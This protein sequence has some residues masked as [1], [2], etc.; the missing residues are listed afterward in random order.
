MW[1]ANRTS[2]AYG[3]ALQVYGKLLLGHQGGVCKSILRRF[4]FA[5]RRFRE[6]RNLW[7]ADCRIGASHTQVTK[8]RGFGGRCL[9]KDIRALIAI[10]KSYGGAP[11]LKRLQNTQRLRHD[12]SSRY[13]ADP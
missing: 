6:L 5:R 4:G 12:R 7:L 13:Q 10:M 8:E 3:G 11:L 1:S 2:R 9:P